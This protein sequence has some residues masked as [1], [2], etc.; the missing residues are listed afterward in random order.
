MDKN[1]PKI[2]ERNPDTGIIRWRYFLDFGNEKELIMNNRKKYAAIEFAMYQL[3]KVGYGVFDKPY[4]ALVNER[5]R[6][7]KKMLKNG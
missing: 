2:Y 4:W 5:S 7:E 3:K 1:R 6:L